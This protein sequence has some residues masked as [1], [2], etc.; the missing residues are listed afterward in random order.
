MPL[1]VKSVQAGGVGAV[2]RNVDVEG[3]KRKRKDC[4][5][6]LFVSHASQGRHD[7]DYDCS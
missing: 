1:C 6:M 2:I 5:F 3:K 7:L 4:S